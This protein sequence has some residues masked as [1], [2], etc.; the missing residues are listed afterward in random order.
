M[1]RLNSL[2]EEFRS[3]LK[4]HHEEAFENTT[5]QD[6]RREIHDMQT[7]RDVTNNMI[8]MNRLRMF[9]QGMEELESVLLFLEY[10]GSRSVMSNVWGVVKFLLKTTNTTDRAFDGVLDVYGLLGAQLMPLARHREF[11]QTYPNAI[12]CL[13]NIY[14]DIQRFHSLAYKLFSLTAKLWQ[15]LQKPIWEDSTRIFKRISESLN[16]TA[17]VIKAQSL[18]SRG[19]SP[20]TSSNI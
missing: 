5:N 19:L 16:T 4:E 8:N 12:E 13:V 18:L 17:K 9:L 1:E 6:M 3:S 2:A 14:Q 10:P 20:Q 7:L 11:F 15:R